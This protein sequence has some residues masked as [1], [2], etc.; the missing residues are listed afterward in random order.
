MQT[1]NHTELNQWLHILLG[2]AVYDPF[3]TPK[4]INYILCRL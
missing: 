2:L 4:V 1:E 3:L